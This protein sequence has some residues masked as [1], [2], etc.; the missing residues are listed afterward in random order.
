MPPRGASGV[1]LKKHD[2]IVNRGAHR[3]WSLRHTKDPLI[4]VSHLPAAPLKNVERF[5]RRGGPSL[6]DLRGCSSNST[7]GR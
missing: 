7:L 1:R 2:K 5:T 6:V 4:D 3:A